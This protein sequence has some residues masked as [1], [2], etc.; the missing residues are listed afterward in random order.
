MTELSIII[1]VYN[2]AH[3]METCLD[4]LMGQDTHDVEIILVDDGSRD[5]SGSI[6][7]QYAL[8]YNNIRVCH[9]TNEGVSMAR[10]IGISMA[11]GR[12]ISFV[13]S[14]DFV[15]DNYLEFFRSIKD[16]YYDLVFFPFCLLSTSGS[17]T[18]LQMEK[19][20]YIGL[21]SIQE[22]MLRLMRNAS[23]FEFLGYASNKFFRKSIIDQHHIRFIGKQSFRED[24]L[25]TLSYCRFINSI[26]TNDSALYTYRVVAGSLSRRQGSIKEVFVYADTLQEYLEAFDNV[27][28]K[29]MEYDRVLHVLINAYSPDLTKEQRK[30]LQGRLSSMISQRAGFLAHLKKTRL[31]RAVF[32]FPEFLSFPIMERILLRVY[33]QNLRNIQNQTTP[34]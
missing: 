33:H 19:N 15:S 11:S 17:M 10:N 3:Y 2:V 9:K 22:G 13:D 32:S 21:S 14:D 5:A 28:F 8:R 7:D 23:N 30:E 34:S 27:H 31:Y 25:F 29:T 18:E 1:P 26:S 24:E 16:T 20:Q 12:W 6:C 4:S